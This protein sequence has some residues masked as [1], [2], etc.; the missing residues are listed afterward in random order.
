MR[1]Y[2]AK[3]AE[4]ELIDTVMVKIMWPGQPVLLRTI[5]DFERV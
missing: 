3:G 1:K 2:E 5:A 4:F